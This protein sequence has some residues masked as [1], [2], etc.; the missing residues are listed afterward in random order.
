MAKYM[1]II[2]PQPKKMV[3]LEKLKTT[4]RYLWFILIFLICIM[5]IVFVKIIFKDKTVS[6]NNFATPE[7]DIAL[8]TNTPAQTTPEVLQPAKAT[9]PL[10]QIIRVRIIN[11]S[12]KPE[13]VTQIEKI[14]SSNNMTVEQSGIV[15]NKFDQT[16]IY[17][18]TGQI[19]TGQKV[20]NL[21]KDKYQTTLDQS[22]TLSDTYDVLIIIGQN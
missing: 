1:D 12:T 15:E 21:L 14:L 17:Y 9:D 16:K 8:Q 7:Q 10:N 13:N 3:V 5:I 18:K 22:D 2:P 4:N 20:Q 19:E 6:Q 11:A